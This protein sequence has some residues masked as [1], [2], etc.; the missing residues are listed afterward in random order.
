M[1]VTDRKQKGPLWQRGM[2]PS[3]TD[4]VDNQI[5]SQW[6]IIQAPILDWW[7]FCRGGYK[8]SL[9]SWQES[10]IIYNT[11]YAQ[12]TEST[13]KAYGGLK[14][15]VWH[16]CIWFHLHLSLNV[17]VH[18]VH[19][20]VVMRLVVV[21]VACTQ[22]FVDHLGDLIELG[23]GAARRARRVVVE[24]MTRRVVRVVAVAGRRH[25]ALLMVGIVTETW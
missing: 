19:V 11:K 15:R 3:E 14:I 18:V 21:H 13:T 4:F 23:H 10:W 17:H 16:T 8:G 9:I 5:T 7:S 6:D 2:W 25:D 1:K 20:G 12:R 24:S 22:V